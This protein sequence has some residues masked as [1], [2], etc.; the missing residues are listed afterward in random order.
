M[1][2]IVW[3][4]W[5]SFGGQYTGKYELTLIQ[6]HVTC[7]LF[8][9][10]C[11]YTPSSQPKAT[12]KVCLGTTF[13]LLGELGDNRKFAWGAWRP[14]KICLERG[15]LFNQISEKFIVNQSYL[16]NFWK[17][18]TSYSRSPSLGI[19][20]G[21]LLGELFGDLIKK[22]PWGLLGVCLGT[23]Q[24]LTLLED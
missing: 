2:C 15:D 5:T 8:E 23:N 9:I 17:C 19:W 14:R 22:F 11:V 1:F 6:K 3:T 7:P 4:C 20:S 24:E 16:P 21:F 18:T 10:F 13:L 12:D